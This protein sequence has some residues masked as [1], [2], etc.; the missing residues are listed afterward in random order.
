MIIGISDVDL[1]EKYEKYLRD[2]QKFH[3]VISRDI[4][5]TQTVTEVY[6]G[7]AT[8]LK[9]ALRMIEYGECDVEEEDENEDEN[10]EEEKSSYQVDSIED[11]NEEGEDY[12][13]LDGQLSLFDE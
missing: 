9:E 4:T 13:P 6:E 3:F 5:I 8:S 12:S 7:E 1:E 10:E 2:G 11:I